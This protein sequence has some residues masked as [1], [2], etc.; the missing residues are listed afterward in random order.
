MARVLAY[1]SPAR[2]H[3]YPLTPI[4]AELRQRGHDVALR[5]MASQVPL[6]RELGFDAAPIDPQIEAIE[7]DDWQATSLPAALGRSGGT[8]LAPA[9]HRRGGPRTPGPPAPPPP[10][11]PVPACRAVRVPAARL[12]GQRG[13]GRSVR[14]GSGRRGARLAREG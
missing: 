10:A 3:L 2:G 1:T 11:P 13:H 7:H 12:A 4:L 6:M 9:R 5:T 14:L 8:F